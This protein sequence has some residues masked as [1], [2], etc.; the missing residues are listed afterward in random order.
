MF[1]FLVF[2]FIVIILCFYINVFYN[3]RI[4][5]NQ[6]M[7]KIINKSARVIRSDIIIFPTR[8]DQNNL[9]ITLTAKQIM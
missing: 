7:F 9:Q 4:N 2:F 5:Y 3:K 8:N 6:Y 1:I